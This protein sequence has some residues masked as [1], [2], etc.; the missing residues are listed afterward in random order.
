MSYKIVLFGPQGAG[1]GTVSKILSQRYNIPHVSTGDIFRYEIKN[2]T[3]LGLRI[4]K[5]VEGGA[6]VPDELVFEVVKNRLEK[7]DAENGFILDGYPRT[8]F[9]AELLVKHFDID[10]VIVL[11]IPEE[12]AIERLSY[13]RI[14]RNCGAIYNLKTNPPKVPGKCDICG[15]PLYQREDDKPEII[16]KRIDLYYKETYPA[17]SI[18]SSSKRIEVDASKPVETV[19]N[20]IISSMES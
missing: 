20:N 9:Q 14:C 16:R 10:Y 3:P 15:G 4:Q 11:N 18:F 17:I 2:R 1:K 7:P 5:Y 19:V 13:R 6:L 8:R 12:V